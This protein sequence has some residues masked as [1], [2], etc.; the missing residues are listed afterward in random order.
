MKMLIDKI[1]LKLL[2]EQKGDYIKSFIN[3]ENLDEI[4]HKFSLVA[5]KD[6]FNSYANKVLLYYDNSW[7]CCFLFSFHTNEYQNEKSILQRLSN[8]LK[9]GK[10]CIRINYI[11][12]ML[13]PK[14]SEK[15]HVHKVYQHSLYQ[16]SVTR[17][18]EVMKNN[19][20]EIEGTKYKWWTL[21][22]METNEN[23]MKKMVVTFYFYKK[24]FNKINKRKA[25]VK[26]C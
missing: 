1:K 10:D 19:E 8:K 21:E 22:E 24:R 2:L 23:I 18:P 26:N 9:I 7:K 11:S 14:Y 3:I 15:D 13:Q 17:F 16:Y 6:E 4:L 25:S 20:F 12:D 5:I